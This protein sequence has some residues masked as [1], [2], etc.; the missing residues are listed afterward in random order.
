MILLMEKRINYILR[1]MIINKQAEI[2]YFA[3]KTLNDCYKF[4]FAQ[5]TTTNS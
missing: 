3:H 1:L 4:L 2:K 5:L